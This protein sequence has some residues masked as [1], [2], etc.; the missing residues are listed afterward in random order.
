M[1]AGILLLVFIVWL[2]ISFEQEVEKPSCKN[3]HKWEYNSEDRL[4]CV[5]CGKK[6]GEDNE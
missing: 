5:N 2:S 4:Q 1:I 3:G 6:P